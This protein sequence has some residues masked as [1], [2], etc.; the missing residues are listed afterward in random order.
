MLF[1]GKRRCLWYIYKQTLVGTYILIICLPIVLSCN[2]LSRFDK[3]RLFM[4]TLAQDGGR[5]PV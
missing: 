2:K 4:A 1:S 3:Q 5:D